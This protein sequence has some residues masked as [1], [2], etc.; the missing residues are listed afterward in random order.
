MPPQVES[1]THKHTLVLLPAGKKGRQK[2]VVGDDSGVIQAF[3]MKKGEAVPIFKHT[4]LQGHKVWVGELT[5]LITAVA[6]GGGEGKQ[7][8]VFATQG[9]HIVGLS[10][11]GKEF[12]KLTSSLSETIHT[13]AVGQTQIWTGC[14]YIYNMYDDGEDAG[15][16]MCPDRVLSLAVD[17]RD[18]TTM[19]GCKDRCIRVVKGS[20]VLAEVATGSPVGALLSYLRECTLTYLPTWADGAVYGTDDGTI[21]YLKSG[22]GGE[23]QKGWEL[24]GPSAIHSLALGDLTGDG[25]DEL[26]VAKDSGALEVYKIGHSSLPQ[27]LYSTKLG[28]SIRSMEVGVVSTVGKPEVVVCVYSG[29]IFSFTTEQINQAAHGDSRGRSI[30]ALQA[31]NQVAKQ[32]EAEISELEKRL[33]KENL[34]TPS[35][36]SMPSLPYQFTVMG[37]CILAPAKAAHA[38]SVEASL[39]IDLVVVQSSLH[40]DLLDADDEVCGSTNSS[41]ILSL[42]RSEDWGLLGCY[43]PIPGPASARTAEGDYGELCLTVVAKQI[44]SKAAQL[45]RFKIKP[46]SL[47]SQIHGDEAQQLMEGRALDVLKLTGS[48]SFNVMHDWIGMCL[49]DVPPRVTGISST[50]YFRNVFTGSILVCSYLKGE[51]T[52]SSD[53][54]SSL[55]IIKE[56]ISR[57]ATSR[58]LSIRDWFEPSTGTLEGFL[59]MLYPRM[60]EQAI[61]VR[62]VSPSLMLSHP[63]G[64][65]KETPPWLTP[66]YAYIAE[67]EQHIKK[68]FKE[69]PSALEFINGV[70]TDLYVDWHKLRGRN[71]KRFIGDLQ[72]LL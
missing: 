35:L 36:P 38:I 56:V 67:N 29:M 27:L 12:F 50:L 62:Q 53:S 72:A 40:V 58:R 59:A 33:K 30:G 4:D 45:V 18:L 20:E 51:A 22:K 41:A 57:E 52:I 64:D 68:A 39:P 71:V 14:E 15:F 9:S 26:V 1:I 65:A 42:S 60:Q 31:Q 55:A 19:L 61:L 46:L 63:T 48:F 13:M 37:K 11:K 32:L 6:L 54:A 47:H 24:P 43:S 3:E 49:P 5:D 28:E 44:N 69:R 21:G 7:D 8:K 70:V 16:V 2:I 23:L 66:E 25:A 17:P 34:L 10:K